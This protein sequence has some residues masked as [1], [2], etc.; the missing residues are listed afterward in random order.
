MLLTTSF[1]HLI[2]RYL[3][4]PFGNAKVHTPCSSSTCPQ[5]PEMAVIPHLLPV[6]GRALD[7]GRISAFTL[8]SWL[9]RLV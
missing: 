6:G 9:G 4:N 2:L 7:L 8:I 1:K 5:E 3:P